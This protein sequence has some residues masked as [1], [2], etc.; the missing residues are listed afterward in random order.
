[1]PTTR[2]I[3]DS[4]VDIVGYEDW[5]LGPSF[6]MR[7]TPESLSIYEDSTLQGM[8]IGCHGER[9]ESTMSLTL[10]VMLIA[11]ESHCLSL[12]VYLFFQSSSCATPLLS[13]LGKLHAIR[14]NLRR[15]VTHKRELN[16]SFGIVIVEEIVALRHAIWN[17]A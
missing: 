16:F 15:R 17:G 10:T 4:A 14:V 9:F 7:G 12:S 8:D 5:R 2:S 3:H 1:M 13:K 11:F 6:V